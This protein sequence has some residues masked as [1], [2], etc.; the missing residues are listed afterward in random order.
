[1]QPAPT[2]GGAARLPVGS[3]ATHGGCC[4]AG[5]PPGAAPAAGLDALLVVLAAPE[6]LLA[7]VSCV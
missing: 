6:A 5:R 1:G 7:V 3:A 2:G 4:G